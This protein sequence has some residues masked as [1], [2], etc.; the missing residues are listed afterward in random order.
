MAE[1]ITR[2]QAVQAVAAY[3]ATTLVPVKVK[4]TEDR[5]IPV[6]ASTQRYEDLTASELVG[7]V[8][9]IPLFMRGEPHRGRRIIELSLDLE[10]LISTQPLAPDPPGAEE[11]AEIKELQRELFQLTGEN[12]FLH[13]L[14][15]TPLPADSHLTRHHSGS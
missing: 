3:G 7:M 13:I 6:D 15:R 4:A 9:G 10:H 14:A 12:V 8:I 5:R 1:P 2:R 11:L